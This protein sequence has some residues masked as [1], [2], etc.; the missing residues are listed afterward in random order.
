MNYKQAYDKIIEAYFKDEI[1]PFTTHF[2]FCGTLSGGNELWIFRSYL[3][4]YNPPYSYEEFGNMEKALFSAF[5]EI[6]WHDNGCV[7]GDRDEEIKNQPDYEEKIF[8]GMCAAIDV[9][10]EIHRSRGENVDEGVTPFVK[11]ELKQTI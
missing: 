9:L 2:C 8:A 7:S 4:G 5:P 1:K 11:R 10:K 3:P 6:E